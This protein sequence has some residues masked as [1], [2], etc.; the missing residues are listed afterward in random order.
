MAALL[1]LFILTVYEKTITFRTLVK[2]GTCL[3]KVNLMKVYLSKN[4]I[5]AII[6]WMYFRCFVRDE[7]LALK[8]IYPELS[9][10]H[11]HQYFHILRSRL[12]AMI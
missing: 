2:V 6:V 8:R 10:T 4:N 1:V 3:A 11:H 7:M 12:L 5:R 9:E